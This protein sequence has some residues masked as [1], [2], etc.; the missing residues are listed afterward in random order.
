MEVS[1]IYRFSLRAGA[2]EGSLTPFQPHIHLQRLIALR[3]S[4]HSR[5]QF[6][7]PRMARL[8]AGTILLLVLHLT[9]FSQLPAQTSS[10]CLVCHSDASLTMERQGKQVS[11]FTDEAILKKSPHRKLVC[12]ACHV[13]FDPENLPHKKKIEPVNCM[14]CHKDAKIKHPFH[15]QMIRARGRNGGDDVSCKGCHG[16]HNV[17]SVKSAESPF[18]SANL[19]EACGRCHGDVQ[20]TFVHSAHAKALESGVK[21]APDCLTCHKNHLAWPREGL[22]E[23]QR[24]IAQ[25]KL[26]LSCHLDDPNVRSRT[27]P[28]AGFIA[29]Y[30]QSVHGSALLEGNTAAANCIDCHGSHEMKKG[31]DPTSLVARQNIPATCGKCHGGITEE[32]KESVHGVAFARGNRDAPVCTDCHGEHNILRHDDPKSPVAPLNVSAQV[33][34]PCHSSV[35]LSEKYGITSDR[36]K[37]FS[38]SYHGLAIRAGSIEVANCASCHGAHNIKHSSDPTSPTHKANLAATCGSCHPGANERFAVGAV[39]VALT[40]EEPILYWIANLYIFLIVTIIGGMTVHN[41]ADFI[42]KSRHKLLLRRG[43]AEEEPVGRSL[44]LRMTLNERLQHGTLAVSFILLVIT[45]FMLRY[46]EA[47]WVVAIRNLSDHVFDLRG[48]M[49]RIAAVVMVAA[50]LYHLYYIFF[51]ERGKELIRDLLPKPQDIYDAI[52]VVKYNFG[53]SKTKP[54]FGRFSYIEKSEYWALVWGTIVMAV[55]GVILWF[56]NT[57]MGLL[58]KLGWDVARTIHFYEAWLATLAILV[59]HFYFVIFNPS[60]YPLNLAACTGYL[61]EAEM[62]EE[63]PLELEEIQRRKM[64]EELEEERR[65]Q[66]ESS[67]EEKPIT[68]QRNA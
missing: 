15:P 49:H 18:H 24:R 60:V 61:S 37:T 20:E 56:D 28:S 67:G 21:G 52:A 7:L 64:Q 22:D 34:S 46:P 16:T 59:W 25:E 8:L 44:Y 14:T 3:R 39:H 42:K 47:D 32:L 11:I 35:K 51:T 13:G 55:T 40:P 27:A 30:E 29:Q 54:K 9:P 43:L 38:D 5:Q 53:F 19:A 36:F 57:F 12:V 68:I 41:V 17:L 65:L 6:D 45:G 58:T 50:S 4:P 10:D 2:G 26:C 33:C 63:H 62:A 48:L 1:N 31:T 66:R 23:G